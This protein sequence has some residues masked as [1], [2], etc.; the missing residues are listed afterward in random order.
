MRHL[1]RC[2]RQSSAGR[3]RETNARARL[4]RRRP[5]SMV[6]G[7]RGEP[8]TAERSAQRGRPLEPDPTSSGVGIVQ[9]GQSASNLLRHRRASRPRS[10]YAGAPPVPAASTSRCRR[11]V[12]L[13]ARPERGRQE[14]PVAPDR[15][16]R[17]ARWR[18]RSPAATGGRSPAGSPGWASSDDLLPW[19]VG[20]A[21]TSRSARGCAASAPDRAQARRRCSRGSAS[22]ASATSCRRRSRAASA[23]ARRSPAR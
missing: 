20:R 8:A 10:R 17:A 5:A 12:D 3:R 18:A 15:R 6:A 21:T 9:L 13:P 11:P 19:L 2:A 1:R 7:A 4:A 14:Q 22:R 23:S 16:P